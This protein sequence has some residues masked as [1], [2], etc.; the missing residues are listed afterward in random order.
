MYN[1]IERNI[2]NPDDLTD[3]EKRSIIGQQIDLTEQE[4]LYGEPILYNED[5]LLFKEIGLIYYTR[6]KKF[7]GTFN[8]GGYVQDGL[9]NENGVYKTVR[10]NRLVYELCH[11]CKIPEKMHVNHIN[12]VRHDNSIS[13][14][15]IMSAKENCNYGHRNQRISE[16]ISKPVVAYNKFTGEKVTVFPS[17]QIAANELGISFKNI[18]N[19]C[20]KQRPSAGDY[21]W[22]HLSENIDKI[23]ISTIYE[24]KPIKTK[25]HAA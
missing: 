7:G 10:R 20:L 5:K 1:G 2:L 18:S 24:R 23:D 11:N 22:R 19:S 13:N 14:L 8:E 3:D 21:I 15:D 17:A 6:E 12:E 25:S 9:K 16:A 4:I